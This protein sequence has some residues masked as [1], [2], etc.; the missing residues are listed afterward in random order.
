MVLNQKEKKAIEILDTFEL[1][2]K[3]KNYKE[4]SLEDTQSVKIVLNLIEK[5][6]NENNRL[7]Q[8]NLDLDRLYRRTAEK[9]K[10]NGKE[11]LANYFLAQIGAVPT[12]ST[13]EEYKHW[14]N[15]DIF[16]EK[17]EKLYEE[18]GNGCWDYDYYNGIA[19]V[20]KLI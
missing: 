17:I 1:R 15:K 5:L 6:V 12:W 11:E 2:K 9:L 18:A 7:V 13:F 8:D 19:A 3:T 4:I 16:L 20:V 14:I 10:E